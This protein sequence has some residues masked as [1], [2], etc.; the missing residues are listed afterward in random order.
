MNINSNKHV[1]VIEQPKEIL[2][3]DPSFYESYEY[4]YSNKGFQYIDTNTMEYCLLITEETINYNFIHYN[5]VKILLVPDLNTIDNS[6]KNIASP[7]I[8]YVSSLLE[9]KS[10][11]LELIIDNKCESFLSE[12]TSDNNYNYYINY[13]NKDCKSNGI[14]IRFYTS[15]DANDE[16]S[17]DKFNEKIIDLFTIKD[18]LNKNHHL[19]LP[20]SLFA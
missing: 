3:A 5:E 2:I 15:N 13:Y 6:V 10:G 1:Y 9:C 16:L 20:N 18:E 4:L 19:D 8:K 11:R 17:F 12:I 14:C 7:D